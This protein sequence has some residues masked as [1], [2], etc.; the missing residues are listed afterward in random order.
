MAIE[1]KPGKGL[2]VRESE[3]LPLK[4]FASGGFYW[5]TGPQNLI[6]AHLGQFLPALT[7]EQDERGAAGL[8]H[9]SSNGASQLATSL[10]L[11]Q[12]KVPAD[13]LNA[14]ADALRRLKSVADAPDTIPDYRVLVSK[15][16][17]P[18]PTKDPELY[19]ISGPLWNRQLY[20]LW[21][22]EKVLNSSLPAEEAIAILKPD[23]WT[24]LKK[25]LVPLALLLLLL[26]LLAALFWGW[27]RLRHALA[28]ALNKPPIAALKLDR[29]DETNRI[30]TISDAGSQDPDGTIQQWLVTW[31]DGKDEKF[32]QAPAAAAHTYDTDRDY[33]ISLLCV[34]DLGATSTPPATVEAKFDFLKRQATAVALKKAQEDARIADEAKGAAIQKLNEAKETQDIAKAAQAKADQ[35]KAQAAQDQEKARKAQ[36]AAERAK[37]AAEKAANDARQATNPL[38]ILPTTNP[39]SAQPAPPAPDP[40]APWPTQPPSTNRPSAAN[41]PLLKGGEA[42]LQNLNAV[43]IQKSTVGAFDSEGRLEA[44]LVVRDTQYPNAPLTVLSWEV[45]GE[46][47]ASGNAQYTIRLPV[48]TH[49]VSVQVVRSAMRKTA[50]AAVIVS[51]Q[52]KQT[53]ES[54]LK[55]IPIK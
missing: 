12:Q 32:N 20:I 31:G 40:K 3:Y 38:P 21:G 17:L 39:P 30:A 27:P 52:Q 53:T 18:D 45:D 9:L 4:A 11:G 2:F 19:R 55:V 44:I 8:F 25:W 37:L 6:R 1:R 29:L 24:K 34:D 50:S 5:D 43:E 47:H 46:A 51:A 15:F 42:T 36:E 54:E 22:C 35:D 7:R 16:Q 49:K 14:L 23:P 41:D 10:P 26:F 13:Q 28:K 33:L 48:G